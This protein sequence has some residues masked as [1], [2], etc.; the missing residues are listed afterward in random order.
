MDTNYLPL[1]LIRNKRKENKHIVMAWY[2]TITVEV[3]IASVLL[4]EAWLKLQ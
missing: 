3:F 4:A 2:V 1:P